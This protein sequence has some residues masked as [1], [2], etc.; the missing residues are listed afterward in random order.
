MKA[1]IEF[2]AFKVQCQ[3]WFGS[4]AFA[5]DDNCVWSVGW[6]S[7]R[8]LPPECMCAALVFSCWWD[9]RL[10]TNESGP[11]RVGRARLGAWGMRDPPTRWLEIWLNGAVSDILDLEISPLFCTP[12]G[13][14]S[15]VFLSA[16]IGAERYQS[17]LE[18]VRARLM[19][20]SLNIADHQAGRIKL[21]MEKLPT[22]GYFSSEYLMRNRVDYINEINAQID[23]LQ[24][25]F[26]DSTMRVAGYFAL[27]RAASV[28]VFHFNK[29]ASSCILHTNGNM[30]AL[31][32]LAMTLET[33]S[34]KNIPHH[35]SV[36]F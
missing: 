3:C 15:F 36:G 31:S 4:W 32:T 9:S 5:Y 8:R 11:F 34:G 6:N 26:S 21:F 1:G 24:V 12:S 2:R 20:G 25:R 10:D 33:I 7:K 30:R 18:H 14:C 17:E 22:S 13:I 35:K 28:V 27:W 16:L 23:V 29:Y 19:S